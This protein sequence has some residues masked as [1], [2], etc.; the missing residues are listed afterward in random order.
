MCMTHTQKERTRRL[1][2]SAAAHSPGL[3]I[4][5]AL[6]QRNMTQGDL[7]RV[8][9]ATGVRRIANGMPQAELEAVLIG[10]LGL[11][12]RYAAPPL[13]HPISLP[14][15]LEFARCPSRPGRLVPLY[16]S[17][18]DSALKQRVRRQQGYT[19]AHCGKHEGQL[20]VHCPWNRRT[21]QSDPPTVMV[22]GNL[23][24]A[25]LEGSQPEILT[26]RGYCNRCHQRFDQL[27]TWSWMRL[28]QAMEG[29][30]TP[31]RLEEQLERLRVA[32]RRA[33]R[34]LG[35]L[36]VGGS[37]LVA[38]TLVARGL[39]INKGGARQVVPALRREPAGDVRRVLDA[40]ASRLILRGLLNHDL[41]LTRALTLPGG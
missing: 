35:A 11:E 4:T 6:A 8:L 36:Q 1:D 21:R 13:P 30:L 32:T 29:N 31:E 34:P 18:F 37:D 10:I 33:G 17:E 14:L 40:A 7:A 28:T 19:C 39:P 20:Y 22:Q 23:Q 38:A 9:A 41:Q 2:L 12:D 27:H 15:S 24:V 25:H 5:R 16:P 3:W 26:V